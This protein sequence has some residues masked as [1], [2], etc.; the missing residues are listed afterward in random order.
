MHI[1]ILSISSTGCWVRISGATCWHLGHDLPFMRQY[2]C[3][4]GA[5]WQSVIPR[6]CLYKD[7]VNFRGTGQV[8]SWG[9]PLH[10]TLIIC[11]SPWLHVTHK[12]YKIVSNTNVVPILGPWES[13]EGHSNEWSLDNL[14]K[15]SV[16]ATKGE[17]T[18]LWEAVRVSQ[19]AQLCPYL[20]DPM[21]C[22]PPGSS[23][24]GILQA[25]ILEWAAISFSRGSSWP[26]DWTQVSRIRG[27][28]FNLW[29]TREAAS[30]LLWEAAGVGIR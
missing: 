23:V 2:L 5:E 8:G 26:R 18:E 12:A 20:C 9:H 11:T 25:R 10:L 7:L 28:R 6:T 22:S 27:R 29:A 1:W 13:R 3:L 17:F 30:L 4:R 21:G 24:H 14:I 19:V 15:T 16:S